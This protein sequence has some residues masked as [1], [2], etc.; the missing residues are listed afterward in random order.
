MRGRKF[1]TAKRHNNNT[2]AFNNIKKSPRLDR[3]SAHQS[4]CANFNIIDFFNSVC[5]IAMALGYGESVA[6]TMQ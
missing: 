4:R 2:P 1:Q 6:V 5:H 3:D